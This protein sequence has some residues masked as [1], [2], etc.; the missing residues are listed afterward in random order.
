MNLYSIK[1]ETAG[2]FM[3]PFVARNHGDA[4]R[5]FTNAVTDT[6]NPDNLMSKHPA[7]FSLYV[8]GEFHDTNGRI[9]ALTNAERLGFGTDYLPQQ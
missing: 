5:S 1:D 7:D 6:R 9:D 4:I 8:L 2:F 3:N